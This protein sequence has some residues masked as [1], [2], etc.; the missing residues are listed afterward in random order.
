MPV[1]MLMLIT[2]LNDGTLIAIGYDNVTPLKTP[3]KWNRAAMFLTASVLASVA[4]AS[5]LLLLWILLD[6]W[7]HTGWFHALGMGGISYGQVTTAIYLKISV[8]DFLTLFSS[9]SGENW[10]WSTRPA[11]ILLVAA[12]IALTA[13]TTIALSWPASYPDGIYALGLG[14]RKPYP[15]FLWIWI[16]CI[17]WWF[18]QDAAKVGVI[19]LMKKFDWLGYNDTGKLVLPASTVEY[20]KLHKEEDMAGVKKH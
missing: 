15:L 4:L 6:S 3:E 13:S 17:V 19:Y 20:I 2:L 16:Y 8:S 14:Y 9:R 12:C 1:L 5:S 18:A 11:N 10:F 7:S